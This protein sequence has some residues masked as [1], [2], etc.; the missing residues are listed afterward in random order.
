MMNSAASPQIHEGHLVD[1]PRARGP[2]SDVTSTEQRA[3]RTTC[4]RP[5]EPLP[6]GAHWDGKG[7]N[8]SLFSEVAERVEVC[9]FDAEGAETRIRLPERTA[10]CWH[11]YLRDV[12]P[13]QR[14]G[15]RVHGPWNPAEGHRCNPAKLLIDPY[16]RAIEGNITW[17]PAVFPYPLG[18]DDLEVE[19][20]DS[21][22]FIPK[23]VVID[24][25]FDW[26]GDTLIRRP[27]HE[28]V[29]YEVHVKGFTQRHPQVPEEL[30]GTYAGLAHPAAIDH[31]TR[32]GITAVELLPIHEFVH[33]PHL[34]EKG[35]R[36]Y[37]GYHSIGYFAPHAAYASASSDGAQVREFKQMVKALHA[38][39]LEVI[40][41]VVYNHTGEGNHLGPVLSLKGIDNR[42]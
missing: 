4:V 38:A 20:S 30:R 2:N 36:N 40:L 21:G 15:F 22:P 29:V 19:R 28:T 37:W 17:N 14:Y 12:A 23:S 39:G 35:L 33:E 8:F 32:L 26:E 9:L 1:G 3:E 6:L 5:G 25:R 11:G 42:A 13:G 31:L 18:G 7:T 10:F 27:L 41:D 16:A 24:D 34:L